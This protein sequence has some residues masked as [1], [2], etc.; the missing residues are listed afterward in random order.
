MAPVVQVTGLDHIVIDVAD[1]E[2]SL[3]W[4]V[5]LL[6]LEPMRV[7]EWRRGEILFPSVRVDASTIID[8]LPLEPSGENINHFCLVVATTDLDALARSGD[9]EVVDGPAV[10]V[11][12]AIGFVPSVTVPWRVPDGPEVQLGNLKLAMRVSQLKSPVVSTYW[13]VYQ[14]V[15]PSAGS[16]T[17]PV[18]LPQYGVVAWLPLPAVETSSEPIWPSGSDTRRPVSAISGWIVA[19]ETL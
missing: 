18:K 1:V 7:D 14:N 9:V 15:Q 10:T 17:I 6:G 11:T 8:L 4:Y 2:R 16:T 3:A 12:P 13:S 19:S 5:D